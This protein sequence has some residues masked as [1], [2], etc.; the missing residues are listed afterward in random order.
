MNHSTG[1]RRLA[2]AASGASVL[3]LLACSESPGST[4]VRCVTATVMD[5]DVT[6]IAVS[7]RA[8]VL[9]GSVVEKSARVQ[10]DLSVTL[11]ATNQEVTIEVTGSS[12]LKTT[13][14]LDEVE[15]GDGAASPLEAVGRSGANYEIAVTPGCSSP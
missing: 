14:T 10:D 8:P 12:E 13:M 3:L 15:S 7:L 9:L 4:E 5:G 6:A 1:I 2:W 11:R